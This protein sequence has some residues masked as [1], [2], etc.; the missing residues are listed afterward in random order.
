MI[1][2]IALLDISAIREAANEIDIKLALHLSWVESRALYHNLKTKLAMNTLNKDEASR[3]WVPNLIYRNNKENDDTRSEKS[4]LKISREGSFSRSGV[5]VVDEI[6]VFEGSENPV[7][8]MQAYTKV[9]K[10]EYHLATFPFDTQ[11]AF[12]VDLVNDELC[13]QVCHVKL[14]VD[15]ADKDSIDLVLGEAKLDM[16]KELTEYFMT[17]DPSLVFDE[18]GGVDFKIIFKR[19]LS[20]EVGNTWPYY[21]F[22]TEAFLEFQRHFCFKVSSP[23]FILI[24]N[25][26]FC[27]KLHIC[28]YT[29]HHI[30]LA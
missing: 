29:L 1:V 26:K 6:E 30:P 19:R 17:D 20:N 9:F 3:L 14:V 13:F 21:Q 5:D 10:C 8:L 7:I 22:M 18:E 28:I 12:T 15:E 4:R 16:G 2:T 11:V 24:Q 23:S 25:P 27:I